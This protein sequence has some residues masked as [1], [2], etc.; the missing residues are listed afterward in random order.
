MERGLS[1]RQNKE[2]AKPTTE[3]GPASPIQ[4]PASL[5]KPDQQL[6]VHVRQYTSLAL[7]AGKIKANWLTFAEQVE[8][9]VVTAMIEG[10]QEFF[11]S[12]PIVVEANIRRT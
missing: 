3:R 9:V 2:T 12:V 6:M 5:T 11:K 7:T 1:A 8:S 10:M 4:A